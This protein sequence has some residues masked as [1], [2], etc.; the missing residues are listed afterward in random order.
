MACRRLRGRD[1]VAL[2]AIAHRRLVD[3]RSDAA[4]HQPM[5][6]SNGRYIVAFN[7]EIYNFRVLRAE[8][9]RD[10]ARFTSDGDTAVL[11]EGWVRFGPAF[12]RRLD[13]MFAFVLWD[14][15]NRSLYV[16]RDVFGIKPLYYATRGPRTRRR[17]ARCGR[18]SRRDSF[19]PQHRPARTGGLSDVRRRCLSPRRSSP[20][21][22]RRPR[23][24]SCASTPERGALARSNRCLWCDA[25]G[26]QRSDRG[27]RDRGAARARRARARR[28]IAIS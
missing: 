3:S 16:A 5:V 19:T 23:A 4:G 2:G 14:E 11:L 1:G 24:P 27:P 17:R 9:E 25:S 18:F 15:W 13:G 10:G 28:S 21:C 22:V 8:L 12:V 26:M 20:A 6:S 7:G